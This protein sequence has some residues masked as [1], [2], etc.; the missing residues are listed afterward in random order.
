M[1]DKLSKATNNS[2]PIS[3]NKSSPKGTSFMSALN[4]SR[5]SVHR[6]R[7]DEIADFIA[8]SFKRS[9]SEKFV[10]KAAK[11][12]LETFKRSQLKPEDAAMIKL[13]KKLVADTLKDLEGKMNNLKAS[14]DLRDPEFIA[15][16]QMHSAIRQKLAK[17]IADEKASLQA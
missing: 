12:S 16:K 4:E 7:D 9:A 10:S 17:L 13:K 15:T 11:R 8:E 3:T 5:T 6:F 14:K 1:I 2:A